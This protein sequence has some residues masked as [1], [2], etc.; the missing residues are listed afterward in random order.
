MPQEWPMMKRIIFAVAAATALSI[1]TP[2]SARSSGYLVPLNQ[3]IAVSR[4]HM[5]GGGGMTLSVSGISNPDNCAGTDLVHIPSSLTGYKEMVASVMAA[6]AAGKRIGSWS[7]HCSILPF[8][9]GG[10]TYPVVADL[11]VMD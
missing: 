3:A 4:Y 1:G 9:G 6:V 10:T 2:H 11:W 8:W 7:S 5:H